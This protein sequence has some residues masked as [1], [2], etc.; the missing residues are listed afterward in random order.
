ML[1]LPGGKEYRHVV[2]FNR[3]TSFFHCCLRR[4]DDVD[5]F[6]A[7]IFLGLTALPSASLRAAIWFWCSLSRPRSNVP[8]DLWECR[9]WDPLCRS[10]V[11]VTAFFFLCHYFRPSTNQEPS[12]CLIAW[13]SLTMM[14]QLIRNRI[15]CRWFHSSLFLCTWFPGNYQAC[16]LLI[17]WF[18]EHQ[19][20]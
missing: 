12:F 8:C 1:F 11:Y 4:T 14:W 16:Y 2:G 10:H 5:L 6:E 13:R 7:D 20:L 9:Q 19:T 17:S 18:T 15:W 3:A